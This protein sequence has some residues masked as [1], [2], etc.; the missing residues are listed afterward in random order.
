[1][2]LKQKN[3]FTWY[4]FQNSFA[5]AY[6][7]IFQSS[8]TSFYEPTWISNNASQPR[9]K[10]QT[11]ILMRNNRRM[12]NLNFKW[13]CLSTGISLKKKWKDEKTNLKSYFIRKKLIFLFHITTNC[14]FI[15]FILTILM[16]MKSYLIVVFICISLRISNVEHVFMCSLAICTSFLWTCL[17]SPS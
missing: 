8:S 6:E 12:H 9:Q 17:F 3:S 4:F 2:K 5:R 10:F 1:M 16:G 14:Y 7:F 15:L 11:K 13:L